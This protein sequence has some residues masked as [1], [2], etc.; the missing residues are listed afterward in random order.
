MLTYNGY[1]IQQ[2]P[3]ENRIEIRL[4]QTMQTLQDSVSPVSDRRQSITDA[5]EFQLLLM[6]I[7]MFEN[8]QE[9]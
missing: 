6:A 4:P 7:Q 9:R 3:K 5:D 2:Y 1:S 8:R